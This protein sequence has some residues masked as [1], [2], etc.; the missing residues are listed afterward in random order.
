M[1]F[2][3]F[4]IRDES[5]FK[6]LVEQILSTTIEINT[7]HNIVETKIILINEEA[8]KKLNKQ[9][10]ALEKRLEKVSQSPSTNVNLG[11]STFDGLRTAYVRVNEDRFLSERDLSPYCSHC[12]NTP[13]PFKKE[14]T[15]LINNGLI[16]MKEN[17]YNEALASL[18]SANLLESNNSNVRIVVNGLKGRCLLKLEKFNQSITYL[19][20]ALKTDPFNPQLLYNKGYAL[21]KLERY[22]EALEYFDRAFE[23]N[24]WEFIII[25]YKL[26]THIKLNQRKEVNAILEYGFRTNLFNKKTLLQEIRKIITDDQTLHGL[27]LN[28]RRFQC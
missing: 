18:D 4:R 20:E 15:N 19:D 27:E 16:L 1:C 21:F 6:Y 22:K 10:L 11:K 23:K 9:D 28:T 5:R 12:W 13:L 8:Y 14:T 3:P 26:V 7:G 24:N 25:F 17:K 2:C